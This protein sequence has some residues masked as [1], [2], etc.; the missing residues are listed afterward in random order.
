[1]LPV[2]FDDIGSDDILKLVVDKAAERKT[3]E[4]KQKLNIA[5]GDERAEFL[6]DISSFANASGGD[7]IFGISDERDGTGN[8]T[9]IPAEIKPLD[10]DSIPTEL[11][12]IE[13]L[14]Q[15]GIQPRIPVVQVKD[16]NVSGYGTVILVRVGK[17]WISPHM[18]TQSN[19]SRFYSRNSSTGKYQL[20]VQ[21]IGAAFAEQRGLGERLRSWKA[22][23]I[24]KA[25]AGEGPVPLEG[26]EILFHFA[27]AA[28][29]TGGG[30]PRPRIFDTQT[31]GIRCKLLYMSAHAMRYNADGLLM[32]S[33]LTRNS[34][35]SYLQI[36]RD[37]SLEYA[38][39]GVLDSAN[40]IS[41]PSQIFEQKIVE[42][43]ANAAWLVRE[44]EVVEP[45]FVSLTLV[46]MKGR[47]MA[48]PQSHFHE[49]PTT[50]PFDRDVILCPDMLIE[51][52]AE[53]PPYRSTLLPIVDAVWQAAGRE[54]TP[55]LDERDGV[56]KSKHH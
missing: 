39:T 12:K 27:S 41:I 43:F 51:N 52:V 26:S 53:G 56:W 3:L 17:S 23:R 28:A 55:Y 29:L 50:E 14:I 48:L 47:T 30:Q 45:I 8:A 9:G 40:G 34:R 37:G 13:Q 4:Y 36:F 20:D 35:Q 5:T 2:R 15:N 31:L 54:R 7:I 21:Q 1:M 42:T 25:I 32:L 19:R 46:G 16:V 6:S 10:F 49:G 38:D 11:G 44:L 18:V 22:D 24:G 33:N